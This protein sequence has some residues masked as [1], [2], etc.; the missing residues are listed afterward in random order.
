MATEPTPAPPPASLGTPIDGAPSS[1]PSPDPDPS[2]PS[3]ATELAPLRYTVEAIEVRGNTTTLTH[4]VLRYVRFHPG[5]PLDVDDRELELT[6]FRLLGTGFFRDVELSLR[7]GSRRGYVVLVVH[8]FERNTI[9]V[10]DLWL[11]LSADAEPDGRARPLTAYGGAQVSETNLGGTGITLGGA[12]AVADRQLALRTRFADPQFLRTAYTV[13]AQLLYNA[14]RDF[15]GNRDVVVDDPQG[16]DYAVLPYRRFGGSVGAGR[17]LGIST[18]LFL[19]YRLERIEAQ[20]P[21]AASHRRGP[22]IEPINFFL[23]PGGSVLSALR[24]TLSHDTRDEP[25]LPMRGSHVVVGADLSS[26]VLG[27]DYPY[28]KLQGR[29]SHWWHLSWGHVFRLE[30]FAGAIFG[31]APLFEK[32]YIGDFSDL[33][34]DRV[35]DLNFDRRPPPNFLDTAIVEVR[36]GDYAARVQGEYRVPLYRGQRSIY[37]VDVF[38]ALGLYAVAE[39]RDFILHARGYDGLRAVPVDLTFNLGLRIETSAGAAVFGLSN[40]LGLLPLRGPGTR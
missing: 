26:G 1:S 8:V 20:V 25:V 11:G 40:F 16:Q 24:A 28:V 12:F 32:F 30:G 38:G 27:S 29:V 36:Y 17:D 10:N 2:T 31:T 7:R 5:D 37:G 3:T 21:L 19:S 34:P 4:L 18:Q 14:A 39:A 15:F 35:L 22:D 23:L 13:E 33:L 6:R 9:V